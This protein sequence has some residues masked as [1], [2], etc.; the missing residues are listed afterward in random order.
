M[1]GDPTRPLPRGPHR[2]SRDDVAASQRSRMLSAI[3]EAV[4]EKGYA[5]TVVADVIKRSG[6]SRATFYE[7]FSSKDD[8]FRAAFEAHA[9]LV[10]DLMTAGLEDL[11]RSDAPPLEKLDNVLSTY[12]DA[13]ASAPALARVFLVEVYA[14]GPECIEQRRRS[15]DVF[16]D[17]VA[18]THDGLDGPLGSRPDQRFAAEVLVAAVSSMVT[19]I[20]AADELDRLPQ[21]HDQLMALAADILVP[22]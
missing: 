6:V 11:R 16:V 21:L 2:L 12:L 1:P 5:N 3:T 14:A 7:Q 8:C 19:A 10:T 17:V 13:L 18:T 22:R 20:V 4:A 9:A 15:L